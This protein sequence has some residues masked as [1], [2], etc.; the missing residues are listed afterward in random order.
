MSSLKTKTECDALAILDGNGPDDAEVRPVEYFI[1][2]VKDS[3]RHRCYVL[4]F[5][6]DDRGYVQ[7][8]HKAGRYTHE[9]VMSQLHYYNSG[10]S[11]VAVPCHILEDV[12]V[13]PAPGYFDTDNGVVVE[14]NHRNWKLI[15][16]NTIAK[17][18]FPSEPQYKG[19][20][21]RKDSVK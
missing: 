12:A 9:H 2:N 11:A 21:R 18:S 5:G 15:L 7:R 8:L 3:E 10:C 17:P 20:R 14:S 16:A 1:V 4:L 6:P 19:A 13:P